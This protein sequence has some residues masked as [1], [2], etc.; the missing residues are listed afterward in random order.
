MNEEDCDPD[1]IVVGSMDLM[2][3]YSVKQTDDDLRKLRGLTG[4]LVKAYDILCKGFKAD[5][6]VYSLANS[7]PT[8]PLPKHRLDEIAE[9]VKSLGRQ[10]KWNIKRNRVTG[11]VD[12]IPIDKITQIMKALGHRPSGPEIAQIIAQTSNKSGDAI[13]FYKFCEALRWYEVVVTEDE[14]VYFFK[15]FLD[16]G[17]GHM[18]LA[19]FRELLEELS[20][21]EMT[22]QDMDDL[23]ALVEATV[24][25]T[26]KPNPVDHGKRDGFWNEAFPGAK[27]PVVTDNYKS[28]IMENEKLSM[29]E[30]VTAMKAILFM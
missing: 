21:N 20:D 23:V 27:I 7:E 13:S 15:E 9:H 6:S 26:Y 12:A 8:P 17:S 28:S 10:F 25:G 4:G 19:K 5:E 1:N 2:R 22:E 14:V 24:N 3:Q 30:F 29:E 11:K 18:T 16:D